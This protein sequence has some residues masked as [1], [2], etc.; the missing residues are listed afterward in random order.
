LLYKILHLL[1]LPLVRIFCAL[2]HKSRKSI[3]VILMRDLWNFSFFGRGEVS[4]PHSEF[5]HFVSG[6]Q[7][8]HQVL[9]PLI[10]LLKSFVFI[11]HLGNSLP[12]CASNCPLLK[13]Q[14]AWNKTCTRLSPSQ[15]LFKIRKSTV[16]GM[17]KDAATILGEIRRSFGSNQ[18]KKQCLPHSHKPLKPI[19]F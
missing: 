4:P 19:Q 18:Q 16:F 5:C 8:K 12:R 10:T 15:I 1:F 17:F 7:A 13:C 9:S 6:S 3:K 14:G 2:R 11:G